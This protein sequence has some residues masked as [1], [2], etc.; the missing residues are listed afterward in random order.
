MVA[1]L[2]CVQT[3]SEDARSIIRSLGV[4]QVAHRKNWEYVFIVRALEK[5]NMLQPRKRGLV[6]A[7]G[8]E[9]LI[10][11]FASRGV[12]VVATDM[13]PDQAGVSMWSST[14][15]HASAKD[16][17]FK[18]GLVSKEEFDRLVT[19]QHADMNHIPK[20]FHGQFDFVWST[21]S[22]EHVGSIS[23]GQRFALESM[24]LLKPGGAGVHTV[25][26]TLSSLDETIE[27]GDTVLWR[28]ADVQRLYDDFGKLGYS[29]D[30]PCWNVGTH[31]HDLNPDRPPYKSD[32]SMDNHIKLL[33]GD[34]VSTSMGWVVQKATP[35]KM[36]SRPRRRADTPR[37]AQHPQTK[38]IGASTK[39][40][41]SF[42]NAKQC[43][44]DLLQPRVATYQEVI[45]PVVNYISPF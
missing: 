17:L 2:F 21:C 14:G 36:K 3:T 19:F 30:A 8:N 31:R 45:G 44:A 37:R 29:M 5:L 16:G 9:P 27:R 24:E 4:K 13:F 40:L 7:A 33:I 1:L 25:E 11:Y 38:L 15:Q 39:V 18:Q 41:Q 43:T 10:S 20:E 42:S 28:Q 26:Y 32:A 35:G 34:H 6:F 22:V 12:E 23:L